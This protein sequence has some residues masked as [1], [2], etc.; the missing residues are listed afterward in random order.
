MHD[1]AER[2]PG[3]KSL[4]N[5][6]GKDDSAR[7]FN[8]EL[9]SILEVTA[10]T[11][12]YWHEWAQL[13]VLLSFRLTQV[14]RQ[15]HKV[16]YPDGAPTIGPPP[17]GSQPFED[18][19]ER[20]VQYLDTFTDET[21]GGGQQGIEFDQVQN[22][23]QNAVERSKEMPVIDEEMVDVDRVMDAQAVGD[24]AAN[25]SSDM[26]DEPSVAEIPQGGNATSSG[27]LEGSAGV[28]LFQTPEAANSQMV[29]D[30]SGGD[31]G[32]STSVTTSQMLL[33]PTDIYAAST[34]APPTN[35]EAEMMHV[36]TDA[37]AALPQAPDA[38]LE[39]VQHFPPAV[40]PPVPDANLQVVQGSL[41][42]AELHPPAGNN[43]VAGLEGS[44]PA[45]STAST[46]MLQDSPA[47]ELVPSAVAEAEL[48]P[49]AV[50]EAVAS[51]TGM[52]Q[53]APVVGLLSPAEERINSAEIKPLGLEADATNHDSL[54]MKESGQEEGSVNN[55]V[56][57]PVVEED[58]S[59]DVS[60]GIVG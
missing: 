60:M 3:S 28:G 33:D 24:L 54:E 23:N 5:F 39:M 27:M 31:G 10:A 20:L 8:K 16:Q 46:D 25:T 18:M 15:F 14:L 42:P 9:R 49:S 34:A 30:S 19:A 29:D 41:I 50:A 17:P 13:K 1:Q 7:E 45:G 22:G 40:L 58:K 6:C 53:D 38:S 43:A 35:T 59:E 57:N 21:N 52:L 32:S 26:Q 48:V 4:A 11:G 56:Q 36:S 51:S 55:H 47:V 12:R 44:N 2:L 37:A